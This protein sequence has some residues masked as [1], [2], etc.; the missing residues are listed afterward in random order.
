MYGPFQQTM[1]VFV[2]VL[3]AVVFFLL[4]NRFCILYSFGFVALTYL[5]Y[6]QEQL[7]QNMRTKYSLLLFPCLALVYA[8][9]SS[10]I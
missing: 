3:I 6:E 7:L 10:S 8:C 2:K 9:F 5:I 1:P 4:G